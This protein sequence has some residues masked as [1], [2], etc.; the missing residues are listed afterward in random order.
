MSK[1]DSFI[2]STS[3][4]ALTR[5]IEFVV[6]L[7]RVKINAIFLGAK[8]VGIV[9]QVAFFAQ[10]MA[11]FT[12]FS[13]SEGFV[14]QVAEN[15]KD[16]DDNISIKLCSAIK[17]Y[18]LM[19]CGFFLFSLSL[20]ISTKNI[21]V[22]YIFES[23]DYFGYFFVAVACVPVLLINGFAFAVLK[24]FK[25]TRY[26]AKSRMIIVIINVV[27]LVPLVYFLRLDGAVIY[28]FI[29]YLVTLVINF[30]FAK[31]SYLSKYK[32]TFYKILHSHI[33]KDKVRELLTFS[34]FGATVGVSLIVSE[35][36]IRSVI[37]SKLGVESLGIYS[38]VIM[39]GSMFTGI[40]LP[41]FSTYLY[42]R[43]CETKDPEIY[44]SLVNQGLRLATFAM[45]PF[46][47]VGIPFK[48]LF[49]SIFYSDEFLSASKYVSIHFC[50]LLFYAWWYVYSQL[51]TPS[52]RIK[53]HGIL[54][55]LMYT[56]NYL[57]V[58]FLID[59]YGL[60]SY[61]FKF[62]ITPIVFFVVYTVYFLF[63]AN[64]KIDRDNF[65]LMISVVIL[66]FILLFF[67][68]YFEGIKLVI[69][70]ILVM[71]PILFF[72]NEKEIGFLLSLRHK[73]NRR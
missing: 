42:P 18:L 28:I 20:A 39:W 47:F 69:V 8:G 25:G 38:P 6:G 62:L 54:L 60:F 59:D 37:V 45:I 68:M 30:Y 73:L 70:A 4:L 57:V 10:Q 63:S 19:I 49:I 5:L 64:V 67:E 71:S 52:G 50:G 56:I 29:S 22:I 72:L 41:T 31:V 14:K 51:M 26:I 35:M 58:Y 53:L 27:F 61:A 43:F 40:I 15:S 9:E 65:F 23:V 7:I 44:Q 24:A 3:L 17:T 21:L 34:G 33:E 55:V 32:V 13:M 66:Y 16:S 1:S 12:T 36:A 2:K 11:I 48:D 46:L